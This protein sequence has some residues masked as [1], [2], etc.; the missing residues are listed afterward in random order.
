M[1]VTDLHAT[2]AGKPV[3]SF[4]FSRP[5]NEKAAANLEKALETLKRA[6]PDYVSV[7]F[8]AG[9]STREGSVELA[10]DLK[11]RKG[12]NVVSYIAGIGLGPE[13]LCACLDEFKSI[14]VQTV[15]VVR[16]DPPTWDESFKPHP[17]ALPH[18]SDLLRFIKERYAFCLGAAGY[19]E[20]H[21]EAQSKDKDLEYAKLKVEQGAD[22]IVTQYCYD[23]RLFFD[24]VKRARA[25]GIAV[26]IFAGIMPIYTVP[27]M[28]SLAKIC[29]ARITD[30]L[31]DGLSKLPADDKKAVSQFGV[32]FATAQCRELLEH[33]VD[34]LHFYTM[35]RAKTVSSVLATLRSEGL[36]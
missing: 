2:K 25:C 5:K 28:E 26:P 18:A 12:F 21:K 27:L 22:Y 10:R 23:N 11:E 32:D 15:L 31:R 35:N 19:P 29:G 30:T 6:E 20:G 17:E 34:G 36:L 33:G 9:G 4:E 24:F 7:T 13:D 3:I 1:R 8:G 16:G 14:G